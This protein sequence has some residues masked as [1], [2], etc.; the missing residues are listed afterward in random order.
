M[1]GGLGR[2]GAPAK[3]QALAEFAIILVVLMFLLLGTLDLGRAFYYQVAL[4]NA[5]RE[6]ARYGAS[7]PTDAAG[8][9]ARVQAESSP[10]AIASGDIAVATP[11]GAS[12]GNPLEVT[13]TYSFPAVNPFIASL[14]GGGNLPIRG[15][16]AMAIMQ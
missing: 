3:G 7:N 8:I 9:V 13:V 6:G 15:G 4:T 1:A 11:N 12:A 16:A 14:W 10:I 5:A 2:A